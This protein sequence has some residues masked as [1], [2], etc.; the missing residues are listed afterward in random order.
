MHSIIYS[1]EIMKVN[2]LNFSKKF[3]FYFNFVVTIKI[4]IKKINHDT[5]Q[6]DLKILKL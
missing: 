3:K 1:L 4:L 5:Y 6:S 2:L